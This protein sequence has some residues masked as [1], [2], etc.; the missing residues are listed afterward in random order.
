MDIGRHAREAGAVKPQTLALLLL[1]ACAA[2]PAPQRAA[3]SSVR[4]LL[5][6]PAERWA[7]AILAALPM[8]AADAEALARALQAEPRA[9]GAPA[10]VAVLGACGHAAGEALLL[11]LVADRGELATDAALALGDR[12]A[13]AAADALAEA[14]ADRAADPSLRTAAACALVR[15]GRA[16]DAQPLLRAV[17]L[18]GTPAGEPLGRELG[19]PVRPRWALER[20]IVQRLVLREG[21]RELAYALDA[22][23]SWPEL[24]RLA[25]RLD[26]WLAARAAR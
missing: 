6:A 19:L 25:D 15:L 13:Q 17:L 10:A 22:D 18:A 21:D 7:D 1:A 8:T 5:D 20:Y 26:A 2:G 3:P 12:K 9:A 23:A 16:R 11:Q 24:E 4:A 14:M